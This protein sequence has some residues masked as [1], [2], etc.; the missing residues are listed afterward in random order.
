VSS[1][2][3]GRLLSAIDLSGTIGLVAAESDGLRVVEVTDP[4]SPRWLCRVDVIGPAKSVAIAGT[5]A[6]VG[7]GTPALHVINLSDP[8]EPRRVASCELGAWS[9][10]VALSGQLAYVAVA[11]QWDGTNI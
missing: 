7:D 11:G 1:L 5:H 9:R 4:R 3:L 8:A 10:S 6:Y 2:P